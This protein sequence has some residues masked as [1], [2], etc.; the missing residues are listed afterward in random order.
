MSSFDEPSNE[1]AVEILIVED[2]DINQLVLSGLLKKLGTN[3]I[4]CASNG[5]I[6]LDK[7]KEGHFDIVFMD[8]QMPVMDGFAATRS[9][10]NL[11]EAKSQTPIIA[12]TA[13]AM[14][15][16]REECLNAG[17]SEYITKPIQET[18]LKEV[19]D[20]FTA[21]IK[22][23]Q[24][25]QQKAPTISPEFDF[26]DSNLRAL[27]DSSL[28]EQVITSYDSAM[29]SELQKLHQ[30]FEKQ[31]FDDSKFVIHSIQGLSG[32]IGAME[33]YKKAKKLSSQLN[34]LG[35]Q[36]CTHTLQSLVKSDQDSKVVLENFLKEYK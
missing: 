17:M 28:V 11:P 34:E 13:N 29:V 24:S 9:I 15:T 4:T 30:A 6:G 25:P 31:D 19:Y 5:Q 7:F 26:D 1:K 16:A 20:R 8:C 36:S 12:I 32:N 3:K 2:N 21:A 22:T 23:K 35:F 33:V 27:E 14:T 18:Q 10:R